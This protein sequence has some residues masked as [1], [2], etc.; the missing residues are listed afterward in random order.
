MT[1]LVGFWGNSIQDSK[2]KKENWAAA[3][4]RTAREK[5]CALTARGSIIEA[6]KGL[7]CSAE[8]GLS[9]VPEAVDKNI[10]STELWPRCTSLRRGGRSSSTYNVQLGVEAGT[11]QLVVH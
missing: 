10:D 7:V 3:D 6:M 4:R 5:S 11:R 8:A 1:S 9:E 2:Q